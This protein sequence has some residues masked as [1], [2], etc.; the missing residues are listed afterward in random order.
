M[1]FLAN[2]DPGTWLLLGGACALICAVLFVL[3]L[4]FQVIGSIVDVFSGLFGL[5]FGVLGG[6]PV[7]WCGCLVALFGCGLCGGLTLLMTNILQTC[8]T[9]QAVN[10][11][12]LLGR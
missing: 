7:S 3:G 4:F 5:V 1:D 8:G 12:R 9:P 6:G 10:F 11:C 2:I